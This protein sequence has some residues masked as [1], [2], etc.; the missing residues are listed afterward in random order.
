MWIWRIYNLMPQKMSLSAKIASLWFV[1]NV[2]KGGGEVQ[3]SWMVERGGEHLRSYLP[4]LM[5]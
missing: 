3:K 4:R 1:S 5:R 2:L